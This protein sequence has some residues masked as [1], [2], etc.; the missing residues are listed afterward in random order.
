MNFLL[1]I[2]FL[3]LFLQERDVVCSI[4]NVANIYEVVTLIFTLFV[5]LN[6]FDQYFLNFWFFTF[7]FCIS[8]I[9]IDEFAFR[10]VALRKNKTWEVAHTIKQCSLLIKPKNHPEFNILTSS[11]TIGV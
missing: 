3:R 6:C 8:E 4:L 5:L 11:K 10:E 9:L 2:Q 1:A 7:L